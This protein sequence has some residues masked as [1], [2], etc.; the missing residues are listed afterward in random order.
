VC[1]QSVQYG[2]TTPTR[3]RAA[4]VAGIAQSWW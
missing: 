2:E 3:G 4:P 1:S